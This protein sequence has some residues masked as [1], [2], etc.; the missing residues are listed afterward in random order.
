MTDA[1]ELAALRRWAADVGLEISDHQADQIS[2]YLELM[3]FWSRRI[4]LVS[5]SDMPV[6]ATKHLADSLYAA[7]QC[8][9]EGRLADLGSGAG[10]PGV[11]IAIVRPRLQVDLIESRAKKISFLAQAT[12]GLSNTRPVNRRIESLGDSDYDFAIARALAPADRLLQM[13][14]PI[15]REGGTLL[16]MKASTYAQELGTADPEGSGF[17]LEDLHEYTL[18]HGEERVIL[19]FVGR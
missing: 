2:N 6:L 3:E 19:R 9:C 14:R 5:A 15:L 8:P 1:G 18:P 11:P 16:A 17:S 13:A 4:A 10:L 7:S 12:Q